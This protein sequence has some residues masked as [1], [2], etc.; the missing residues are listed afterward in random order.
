VPARDADAA[1][2]S[3]ELT[4]LVGPASAA[5]L[6]AASVPCGTTSDG[7][8]VGLQLVGADER[9]VLAAILRLFPLLEPAA[10]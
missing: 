6:A 5:G 3:V 4:P 10:R 9:A 2:A 1:R 8:P 7:L